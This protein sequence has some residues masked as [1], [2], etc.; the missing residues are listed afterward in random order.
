MLILC[1]ECKKEVS[2]KAPYCIHCG[3]PLQDDDNIQTK[4]E[5]HKVDL[6]QITL[7][8][9]NGGGAE[10]M[11]YIIK[12]LG[13]TM[14]EAIPMI[15][16]HKPIKTNITYDEAI[17]IKDALEKLKA[18]VSITKM[19]DGSEEYDTDSYTKSYRESLNVPFCPKCGSTHIEATTRGYSS[20][21]GFLGS[22]TTMNYC[23]KCGHKWNP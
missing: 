2:D 19:S 23:K 9:R 22:G 13:F 5:E 20:F 7:I 8:D 15:K 10:P 16:E 21:W 17:A 4:K 12:E 14:E 11:L 1:P 6:Y 18:K 3:Y